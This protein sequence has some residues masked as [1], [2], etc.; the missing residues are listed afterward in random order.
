MSARGARAGRGFT[1]LEVLLAIAAASVLGAVVFTLFVQAS[2]IASRLRTEQRLATVRDALDAYY[3]DH[4]L[5]IEASPAGQFPVGDATPLRSGDDLARALAPAPALAMLP[6]ES[7]QDGWGR[8]FRILVS[9]NLQDASTGDALAFRR[10]A[11]VSAGAN[12]RFETPAWPAGPEAPVE[13]GDDFLAVVDGLAIQR[14]QAHETHRRIARVAALVR[15]L[16]FARYSTNAARDITIDYFGAGPAAAGWDEGGDLLRGSDRPPGPAGRL[17]DRELE[18]LGLTRGE[19]VDAWG[20]DIA[21]END[22]DAVRNP[23]NS[24]PGLNTPPYGA[25]VLASLPGGGALAESID[26]VF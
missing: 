14:L 20:G 23:A 25:R 19:A 13:Q 10:L 7:L 5:A 12:G 17:T 8:S 21:L 6:R 1:A 3:R 22:T 4:T 2:S 11:I 9:G 24:R 16:A 26:G 15:G 18:V